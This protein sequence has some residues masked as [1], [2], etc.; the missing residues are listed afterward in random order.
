MKPAEDSLP[1][2]AAPA[3]RGSLRWELFF[4]LS[5]TPHGL[6]DMATPA[7]AALLGLGHFPPLATV[8]VG[9]VTAFSG[10]TAVY[11]LNDIVDYRVDRQRLALRQ[12]AKRPFDLDGLLVPHPLARRLLSLPKGLLW[13]CFWAVIALAGAWWL[14]PVCVVM[15]LIVAALEALYCK[16]LKV[17]WLKIIPTVLVKAAGGVVGIYAVDPSPPPGYVSFLILWLASWELGGQNVVNDI[18][19]LE[20]DA[21]VGAKTLATVLGVRESVFVAVAAASM[22]AFAGVAIYWL[23]GP[24]IGP[25]Y[26]LG[27]AVIGW[28]LL[29]QPA[30]KLY[31]DP[32]PETA[33]ALFNR[34]SYVPLAFL[35]LTTLAL[36]FHP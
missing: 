15:F 25:I 34:A 7:M 27:A 24:G 30:R 11:A 14:N 28:K 4:G 19:D 29:L 9:I 2:T 6:L 36:V 16:L 10:Y 22:A 21:R 35:V 13:F 5:R 26:P 33:A 1:P 17:T 12:D 31:A 20:D 18:A 3:G 23:S 8:L 32:C